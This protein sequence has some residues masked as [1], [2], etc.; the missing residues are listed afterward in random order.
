MNKD[1]F[2]QN[3]SNSIDGFNPYCKTC[4]SIRSQKWQRDNP[5]RYRKYIKWRNSTENVN[6]V[7][8]NRALSKRKR[9]E[10][11]F[12]EYRDKNKEKFKQYQ[13]NREKKKHDISDTQ[14]NACKGY[15]NNECA[16]CGMSHKDHKE[17]I[18][19]DLHREHVDDKGA[20]DLSNCVPSCRECNSH[21]W[22]FSLEEWYNEANECF[23][24]AR[25]DKIH[26]WLNKDFK[27]FPKTKS[28]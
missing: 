5:E 23:S 4:N 22:I 13:R 7:K 24:K 16:Y 28:K 15:F 8:A 21:K 11:K 27:Q 2:Y 6:F 18:G 14:W 20:N 3:K 1:H 25:L 17:I 9:L 12:K 26:K 19:Q 10:G